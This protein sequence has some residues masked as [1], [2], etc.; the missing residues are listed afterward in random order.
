MTHVALTFVKS[1]AKPGFEL[2]T[3]GLTAI[4]LAH[5]WKTNVA[6]T[7]VK[8]WAKPGFELTTP[9]LTARVVTD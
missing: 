4:D 2:T 5:W 7:F 9:G 3:P 6:L 1:W 8:S